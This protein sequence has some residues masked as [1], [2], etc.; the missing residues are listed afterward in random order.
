MDIKH[1]AC[2]LQVKALAGDG[3]FSGYASVFGAIDQQNEIVAAGAFSRT[4]RLAAQQN[5]APAMLWMH[6]PTAPIGL[7]QLIRE[8]A[9][10][11][12]VEGRLA[13]RTQKGADAYEL[14]KMGAITGLSIGYRVVASRVDAKRKARILTDVDLFEISLVTFPANEAARVSEVKTPSPGKAVALRRELKA[15]AARLNQAA[16]KLTSN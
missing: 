8:D 3:V 6:D 5:R 10:G 15:A 7:W 12:A 4:L 9:N 16:R 1:F 14:L 11:L 2:A 13:L